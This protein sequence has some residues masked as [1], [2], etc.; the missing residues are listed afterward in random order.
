[1]YKAK[2]G[3]CGAFV[4]LGLDHCGACFLRKATGRSSGRKPTS[5]SLKTMMDSRRVVLRRLDAATSDAARAGLE[6][7]LAIHDRRIA[8]SGPAPTPRLKLKRC[9]GCERHLGL[10]EASWS[11]DSGGK[12]WHSI[13]R[14]CQAAINPVPSPEAVTPATPD[15]IPARTG[16]KAE[17][18][19]RYELKLAVDKIK[20]LILAYEAVRT[21]PGHARAGAENRLG[22]ALA[23]HGS[24]VQ[25]DGRIYRWVREEQ[26]ISRMKAETR[27]HPP[28]S[29]RN[30]SKRKAETVA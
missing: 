13:C 26:S 27:I 23:R 12:R 29:K 17:Q 9:P 14:Q 3:Q 15:P 19:E 11:R 28:K 4:V 2:C 20:P 18:A 5:R 30:H 8:S 1:M 6:G 25:C 16:S 24:S 21:L 22:L 10:D 7:L